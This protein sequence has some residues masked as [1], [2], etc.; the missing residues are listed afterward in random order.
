MNGKK[1]Q[2]RDDQSCISQ[3]FDFLLHEI[4]SFHA[5]DIHIE[6]RND[7]TLIRFRVDEILCEFAIFEKDIYETLVFHIKFLAC[8]NLAESRKTQDGSFELDFENERYDFRVSCL[9][10][11]Y[12]ESV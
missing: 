6:A 1:N 2:K 10:L 11:I 5:S 4:L 9:P 7:D 12:G 3:I 8:L